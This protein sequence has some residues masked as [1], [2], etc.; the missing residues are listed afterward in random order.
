MNIASVALLTFAGSVFAAPVFA[1]SLPPISLY[2]QISGQYYNPDGQFTEFTT[3]N[4]VN[5]PWS[6]SSGSGPTSIAGNYTTSGLPLISEYGRAYSLD[7]Q[8]GVDIQ[9]DIGMSYYFRINGPTGNS[10]PITVTAT[11]Q[12][13]GSG[14]KSNRG[15]E[16]GRYLPSVITL[17]HDQQTQN[18]TYTHTFFL[19]AGDTYYV[20]M[21]A[22]LDISASQN[23]LEGTL[24]VDPVFTIDPTFTDADQYSLV[25]SDGIANLPAA[26]TVPGPI[27]G[28]GIPGLI[29]ASGGLLGWWRR[30]RKIA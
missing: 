1:D 29:L 24:M 16:L 2:G 27:V 19:T 26:A 14:E 7:K 18:F 5:G 25:F 22:D 6:F 13:S 28:A 17:V 11:G 4:I 15:F 10:V 8:H 9:E 21:W 20:N 3:Q 23:R 12:G 30:R